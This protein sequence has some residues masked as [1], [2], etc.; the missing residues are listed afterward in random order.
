MGN[1]CSMGK[2]LRRT[3]VLSL[4]LAVAGCTAAFEPKTITSELKG[5]SVISNTASLAH[6]FVH[7]KPGKLFTCSLSHPDAAFDQADE[8]DISVSLIAIDNSQTDGGGDA[9]SSEEAEMAGRT[10]AVLMA[11]EL[12]FRACELSQNL[13]LDKKEAL[14]LYNKTLDVVKA[15]WTIEAG[16]TTVTVGDTLTVTEGITVGSTSTQ[17]I[18]D[19]TTTSATTSETGTDSTTDTTSSTTDDSTTTTDDESSSSTDQ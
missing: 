11:R 5:G 12:F 14:A 19:T 13:N 15:V 1:G 6:T 8:G 9:E 17:S 16:N 2:L 18:S 3:G 7:T 10:P 4:A